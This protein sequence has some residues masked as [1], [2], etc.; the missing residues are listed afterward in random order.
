MAEIGKPVREEPWQVPAPIT[1]PAR[2]EVVPETE[3]EKV[4]A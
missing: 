1:E 2:P 4:P 3:P